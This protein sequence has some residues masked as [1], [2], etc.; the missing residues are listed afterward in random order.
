[1]TDATQESDRRWRI[2]SVLKA[3]N[4]ANIQPQQLRQLGVYGGAQGI[5]VDKERTSHVAKDGVTVGILHT[6]R[7]YPDDVSE[8]GLIYHYP[9]TNRPQGRDAAEI[10]ATKN[11]LELNLPIF[12]VLPGERQ[13]SRSVRLGWVRDFDD[14]TGQFLILFGEE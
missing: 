14:L 7:H 11:S 1:M 6:G 13:T 9:Q 8:D 10:Q 12:V 3:E 4:A 5:W 2:W